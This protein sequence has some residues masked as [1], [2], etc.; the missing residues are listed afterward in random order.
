MEKKQIILLIIP[1]II[2][3]G[4][5]FTNISQEPETK[6]TVDTH[7]Q[8][9]GETTLKR[10]YVFFD[11]GSSEVFDEGNTTKTVETGKTVTQVQVDVWYDNEALPENNFSDGGWVEGE[12]TDPDG[13]N[14]YFDNNEW[15]VSVV[16]YGVADNTNEY[17][18][19][20]NEQTSSDPFPVE[21]EQGKYE[22]W[23]HYYVLA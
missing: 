11:D 17:S 3:G 20:D 12:W 16:S 15:Y 9:L 4:F 5:A 6:L 19:S 2:M 7:N 18:L 8:D 1:I 22:L 23:V 13:D 21:L 10:V 14:N